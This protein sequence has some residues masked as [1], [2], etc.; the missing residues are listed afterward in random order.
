MAPGSEDERLG[1]GLSPGAKHYRAFVGPAEKYDIVSA[2][3]FNLMTF[4][5]LRENHYLLDIG[6]GSLRAG[7]LFIPYLLPGRYFGIEPEKW[8]IE[9]GI[10]KELGQDIIRVKKPVFSNDADF[11]LDVFDREFDF[12]MA[13]SIFTHASQAQIRKCLSEAKKVMKPAA[14]FAANYIGGEENYEGDEWVYPDCCSYTP[15]HMAGLVEEQGLVCRAIDW[16]HPNPVNWIAITHPENEKNLP[17]V[18]NAANLQG[19]GSQ[20]NDCR[21]RLEELETDRYVRYG[22]KLSRYLKKSRRRR[23]PQ[24]SSTKT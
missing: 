22:I 2:I 8:L 15:D 23:T 20:L 11:N 9:E 14:V 24:G 18:R 7:K 13:Q 5:G 4:L 10:E 17:D 19:L 1:K 21:T 6:C 3:Q 16:P 12:M